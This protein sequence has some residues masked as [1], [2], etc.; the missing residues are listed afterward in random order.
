[1]SKSIVDSIS[2]EL[3]DE[4]QEVQ[5]TNPRL[6]ELIITMVSAIGETVAQVERLTRTTAQLEMSRDD[7][8]WKLNTLKDIT[9]RN[10]YDV[11]PIEA[12][13]A[14]KKPTIH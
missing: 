12:A 14:D 5:E 11:D 6:V 3:L 9:V 13:E 1:M 7:H 4:L 10:L 8:D 2:Q